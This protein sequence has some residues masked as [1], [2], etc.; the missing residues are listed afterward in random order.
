MQRP[1]HRVCST[2]DMACAEHIALSGSRWY[3]FR[4]FLASP[5]LLGGFPCAWASVVLL[6]FTLFAP[7]SVGEGD[8][9]TVQGWAAD[10]ALFSVCALAV[11]ASI[12]LL[13]TN[14]RVRFLMQCERIECM[15]WDGKCV[16]GII[17]LI[18]ASTLSTDAN[19]SEMMMVA[20]RALSVCSKSCGHLCKCFKSEFFVYQRCAI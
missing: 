15:V 16:W 4:N 8:G 14:G 19:A 5:S 7:P 13:S 10:V 18:Y 3:L 2:S 20:R 9:W 1:W 6:V 12:A 17:C 11:L